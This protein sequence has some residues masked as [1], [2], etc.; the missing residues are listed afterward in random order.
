MDLE[1]LSYLDPDDKRNLGLPDD[2]DFDGKAPLTKGDIYS[3]IHAYV[4]S[5]AMKGNIM[6]ADDIAT[7]LENS[8]LWEFGDS[9]QGLINSNILDF[10]T[11]VESGITSITDEEADEVVEITESYL[12][13]QIKDIS[14][15]SFDG[16]KKLLTS[17]IFKDL[18]TDPDLK[19][20]TD[21]ENVSF[22]NNPVLPIL[23]Q[24]S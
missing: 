15:Q 3:V 22:I 6:S 8:K 4:A 9:E 14:K 16:I 10:Y 11:R 2:F 5:Q 17:N 20:L 7:W 18:E 12:N 24:I 1:A 21:L 19:A 23:K 13:K